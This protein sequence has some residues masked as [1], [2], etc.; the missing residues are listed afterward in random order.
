MID[1][2]I[3]FDI[4]VDRGHVLQCK[5]GRLGEEAHEAETDVVL[6]GEHVLV[7]AARFHDG[8]HVHVVERRQQ[9]GIVLRAL[10]T[11]GDGLAHARH[12]D[13]LFTALARGR[14]RCG[15]AFSRLAAARLLGF[16]RSDH[17]FLGQAAVLA[18]ALDRGRI[19]TVFEHCA[20]HGRR[21]RL[22]TVTVG[23]FLGLSG[24]SLFDVRVRFVRLGCVVAIAGRFCR[25]VAFFD[26]GD[27]CIDFDRV[28]DVDLEFLDRA[29]NGGGCLHRDLVGFQADDGFIDGDRIADFLQQFAD[30]RFGDRFTQRRNFDFGGHILAFPN[31]LQSLRTL[32]A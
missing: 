16:R 5:T 19:D 7:L 12:L 21:K 26:H 20:A 28:A 1:D 10:E 29:G 27:H 8:R 22:R 31:Y 17:I 9:R 3:A 13:A 18:G 24:R 23:R 14:C 15:C 6:L 11:L 30:G 25:S 32:G 4:G 2:L